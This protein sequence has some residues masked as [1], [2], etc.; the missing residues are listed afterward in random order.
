M[1][2][3]VGDY[4]SEVVK[5]VEYIESRG[6]ALVQ[7]FTEHQ[8]LGKSTLRQTVENFKEYFLSETKEIKNVLQHKKWEE[9]GCTDN[10]HAA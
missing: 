8:H 1:M 3:I 6:D 7:I 9:K 4:V 10:S 2:Q 5:L